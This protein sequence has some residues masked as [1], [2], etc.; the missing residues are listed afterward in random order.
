MQRKEKIF[1][2]WWVVLGLF[3]ATFFGTWG[4]YITAVLFSF[5]SKDMGWS[6]A[7]LNLSISL[8]LWV[9]AGAVII[10][11]RLV[12]KIGG[13]KVIA[14]GSLLLILGF[15]LLS[16]V[17]NLWQLYL[18]HG[19]ILAFATAM[20]HAVPTQAVSRKWFIEK[21]GLVGALM[22][23]AFAV[24]QALLAPLLTYEAS[25]F[26]WRKVS[27][28]AM[29]FGIIVL[30]LTLIFIKD[31][32]ESVGL[33]PYGAE[34]EVGKGENSSLP[35]QIELTAAQSLRTSSFWFIFLAYGLLAVPLQG[36]MGNAVNWGVTVGIAPQIAGLALSSF[37]FLAV[38]GKILWGLLG[39]KFGKRKVLVIGHLACAIVALGGWT[40]ISSPLSLYIVCMLWGV[41]YGTLALV[42][43][44]LGD[45][46]GRYNVGL[47]FGIVTA[48]HGLLGGVGPLLW[49][50]IFDVT[51]AYNF[52]SF[53]S[54]CIYI[55]VS[56]CFFLTRPIIVS[57]EN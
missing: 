2:G 32:P 20:T 27:L 54:A 18:V 17:Q 49:G 15:Y 8:A 3:F 42:A 24:S 51:G 35:R 21:A 13:Q 11:G 52:A 55:L 48:A 40:W 16:F 36:F 37:H 33:L 22:A 30:F 12:D 47:L 29:S 39:D 38:P 9:Y 44:Y 31:T 1:F 5:I 46:F 50:I 43:P 53:T 10:V 14:L 26:G 23:M 56:I 41:S 25:I 19:F 34:K 45:L 28:F 6:V 7:S 57:R 4:R